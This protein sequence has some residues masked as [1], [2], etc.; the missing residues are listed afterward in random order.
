MW[1]IQQFSDSAGST[2]AFIGPMM[3]KRGHEQFESK[4]KFSYKC[5]LVT[6]RLYHQ[7]IVLR[8]WARGALHVYIFV[9]DVRDRVCICLVYIGDCR[10]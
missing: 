5:S 3:Y 8:R 9:H 10:A 4:L 7:K 1:E 2:T 6:D